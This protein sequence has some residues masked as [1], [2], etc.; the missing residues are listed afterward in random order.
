MDYQLLTD[1]ILVKRLKADDEVAFKEIYTRYWK[2]L[3]KDAYYRCN[4]KEAAKE[5]IQNLFLYI[6]EKRQSLAIANLSGY[7]QTAVK[8]RVIN[9]IETILVQKK[10]QQYVVNNTTAQSAETEKTVHYNELYLAF[11]KAVE[12][13]PAKTRDVFTMSRFEQLSIK[14]IA[15]RL[16]ISE[17]TVEYHIT[18]SLKVLRVSLKDYMVGCV[19]IG[20]LASF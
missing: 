15:H 11:Q 2:H 6:W 5:I 19:A 17:K 3:F 9:Y 4:S 10:H 7:L 12:A 18:S 13:L 14:E 1:E 8:N 20:S 16:N